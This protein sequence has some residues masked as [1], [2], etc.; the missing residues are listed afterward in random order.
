[1]QILPYKPR[2]KEAFIRL[3]KAWITGY[4]K[5]LEK[6][7]L[8][9]LEH[10][11]ELIRS[12]AMV[13]A[14]AQGNAVLAVCMALP[15]ENG[16]WEICKLAADERYKGL[17]AGSAVFK[18]CMDHALARGAQK[19]VLVSNHILKPALHI[20]EKYGF[21]QVPLEHCEYARGDVRYEYI[22]AAKQQP[23]A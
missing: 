10:V 1:M 7:D 15:L 22:P 2:F 23:H 16:E 4:F 3:N 17:G 21:R 14:A 18:A 11:E 12:G 6:T 19:L 13:Y 9:T 8:H 20:Y 5:V